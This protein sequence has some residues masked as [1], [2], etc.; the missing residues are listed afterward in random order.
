[1]IVSAEIRELIEALRREVADLRRENETRAE[2]TSLRTENAD[3]RRRLS[4][5]SSNSSKPPSRDGLK[6]PPRVG[7]PAR[8][9]GQAEHRA[10]GP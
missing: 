3:M 6:K 8:T 7:Q 2:N 10:G 5:E 4:L 1:M 9:L